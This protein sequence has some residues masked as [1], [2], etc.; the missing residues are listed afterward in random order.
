MTHGQLGDLGDDDVAVLASILSDPAQRLN[1][2]AADNLHTHVCVVVTQV[3]TV[4]CL[5]R[6]NQCGTAAGDDAL[7]QSCTGGGHSILNAVLAFLRLNLGCGTD[8]DNAHAAGKLSQALLELLAVPFGIHAL[9]FAAQLLHAVLDCLGVAAAVH[10]GG[11]GLGDGHAACRAQVLQGDLR[12]VNAELAG[13]DGAAGQNCQV[14]HD[15]LAAVTETGSLQSH[16]VDGAAQLVHDQC[17][18]RLAVNVFCDDGQR[19]LR[20][21]DLLEH[22]HDL[23]DGGNLALVE[24]HQGV[25]QHCFAT[26]SV[27]HEG[28]RE[29]ALVELHTFGDVQLNLGGG[30]VFDGD[31][32]V[33]TNL[34]EGASQQLTNL[35]GLRGDS[36][37]VRHL[38]ALHGACV[39]E[40]AC[41]DSL[42]SS[43]NAALDVGGCCTAGDVAQALVDQCLCEHGCGGGTVT[44]YVV[45]L[46]GDFLRQLGAQVLVRVVQFNF[47]GDGHAVVG[48]DGCTPL[49]VEHNIAPARAE[50]YL[51]RVCQLI[52]ASLQGLAGGIVEFKL[53]SHVF[54]T[55]SA[56]QKGKILRGQMIAH[57]PYRMSGTAHEHLKVLVDD[58][59]NVACGE[60]QV[61]FA[62]VLDLGATVAGEHDNVAFLDVYGDAVAL[63]IHAARTN[64]DNACFLR[65]FL[66]SFGDNQTGCGGLLSLFDLDNDAVFQRLDGHNRFLRIVD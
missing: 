17:G 23:C 8:L 19:L 21:N 31:D 44:G 61:L 6:V 40:Q 15:C 26:L 18:E 63:L 34:L 2:G 50:G 11:V 45:G 49:L 41:G 16:H 33:L 47:A 20:L 53:L 52:D 39:L 42:H 10:D 29:V 14:L 66:R 65:L 9:D 64:G 57:A 1:Q 59:Q 43:L 12:Q 7:F 60:N 4:Q 54:A 55:P 24:Q 35:L 38:G 28:G 32:A 37:D 30:A 3:H 5:Q 56:S 46:G 22:G 58:C 62:L 51:D 27:G 36:G 48:D 13:H 25:L